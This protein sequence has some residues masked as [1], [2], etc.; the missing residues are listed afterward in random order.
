MAVD[1]QDVQAHFLSQEITC[2]AFHLIMDRVA[3]FK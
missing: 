3:I 1:M 2:T